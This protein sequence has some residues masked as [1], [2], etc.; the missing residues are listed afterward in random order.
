M[1]VLRIEVCD[2]RYQLRASHKTLPNPWESM[3]ETLIITESGAPVA[4][5]TRRVTGDSMRRLIAL[6]SGVKLS[7]Y[8]AGT[9]ERAIQTPS[10]NNNVLHD[11]S[12]SDFTRFAERVFTGFVNLYSVE[13]RVLGEWPALPMVGGWT[14][15]KILDSSGGAVLGYLFRAYDAWTPGEARTHKHSGVAQRAVEFVVAS[16]SAATAP[17]GVPLP[18]ASYVNVNNL[19]SSS[20]FLAEQTA[21]PPSTASMEWVLDQQLLTNPVQLGQIGTWSP[22]QQPS[23]VVRSASWTAAANSTWEE[24]FFPLDGFAATNVQWIKVTNAGAGGQVTVKLGESG[25][26]VAITGS[27]SHVFQLWPDVPAGSP[28]DRPMKIDR[29]T[30]LMIKGTTGGTTAATIEFMRA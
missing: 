28:Y 22:V 16:A 5:E 25:D 2:L 6:P 30:R 4:V 3:T 9:T 24:S 26:E 15:Y 13:Q 17:Y 10:N 21:S 11:G 14:P 20:L 12:V 19:A 18:L 1:F 29:T 23:G 7:T 27:S 8:M